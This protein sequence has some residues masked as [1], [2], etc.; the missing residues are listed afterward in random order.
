MASVGIAHAYQ[1]TSVSPSGHTLYYNIANGSA[2]LV[3]PVDNVTNPWNG[4]TKPTGNVIIPSTVT[5]SGVTY[6]VTSISE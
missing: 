6:A 4:Y 2:R 5:Y 3:G 1:F